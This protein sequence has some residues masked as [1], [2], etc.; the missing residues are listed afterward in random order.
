M[1][2]LTQRFDDESEV[3]EAKED[4]V[5]LLEAAEDSAEAS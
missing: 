5:E 3:E 2:T 1:L 4:H